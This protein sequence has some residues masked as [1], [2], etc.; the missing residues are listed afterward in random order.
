MGCLCASWTGL[1]GSIDPWM[2]KDILNEY[3]LAFFNQ[4]LRGTNEELLKLS[5]T[6]RPEIIKFEVVDNR[7]RGELVN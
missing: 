4:Y 5:S 7:V 6:K 3:T 2:M 1:L